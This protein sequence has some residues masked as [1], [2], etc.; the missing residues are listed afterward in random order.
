MI[1]LDTHA[2]VWWT[3]SPELLSQAASDA[4][5]Q[6]DIVLV[7]AISFWEVALLVRKKRLRLNRDQ[8]V[9]AWAT[10]L[11][12]IPRVREDELGHGLVILADSLAMHPD[13]ADRFIAATSLSHEATLVTKDCLMQDLDWLQTLW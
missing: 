6:S 10:A 13:P 8:S 4:I 7:S 12:A 1:V 9:G 2:L 3:Q 11:M 5:E